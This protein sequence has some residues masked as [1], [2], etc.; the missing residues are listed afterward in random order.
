MSQASL[1]TPATRPTAPAPLF[2]RDLI[3]ALIVMAVASGI[4]CLLTFNLTLHYLD[5][6]KDNSAWAGVVVAVVQSFILFAQLLIFYRQE[7]AMERQATFMNTQTDS[8][9]K[10]GTVAHQDYIQTHRP[11]MRMREVEMPHPVAPN[12]SPDVK[13][14]IK[15][16]GSTNAN[17]HAVKGDVF[18]RPAKNPNSNAWNL[19]NVPIPGSTI[20]PGNALIVSLSGFLHINPTMMSQINNSGDGLFLMANVFYTDDNGTNHET[21]IIRKYDTIAQRFVRLPET[22]PHFEF[23]FE[24]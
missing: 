17:I 14:W 22:D 21:N 24:D 2:K 16:V 19:R 6:V 5:N 8:I 1:P 15:N 10:Q 9:V 11:T 7:L 20:I 23:E 13:L 18:I 12:G 4:T 3:G